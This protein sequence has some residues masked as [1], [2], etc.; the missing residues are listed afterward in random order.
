MGKF[1]FRSRRIPQAGGPVHRQGHRQGGT[2]PLVRL[3]YRNAALGF[4]VAACFVTALVV[5]DINGL[6]TLILNS[7]DG[8]IAAFVL[9]F[10][11]GLTFASVQMAIAIMQLAEGEQDGGP[12]GEDDDDEPGGPRRR[13]TIHYRLDDGAPRGELV[14]VR[15]RP[16]RVRPS[17]RGR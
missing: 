15:V 13:H 14:P 11:T 7:P 3:L 4:A 5:F 1:P 16:F 9:T 17:S 12:A 10:A 8:A 6:G 2:P